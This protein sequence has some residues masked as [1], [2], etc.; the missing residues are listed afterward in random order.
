MTCPNS[1]IRLFLRLEPDIPKLT[2]QNGIKTRVVNGHAQVYKS[3]E[4]L[5]LE[6]KYLSLLSP[7][8]P[9]KPWNCPIHLATVWYFRMPQK[10]GFVDAVA[11]KTTK[12]DTDNLVKTLKDCL[13][14]AGFFK[15]DAL[16]CLESI[17]KMWAT[18]LQPHGV[19]ICMRKLS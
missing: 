12:P 19:E 18:P 15:D 9:Q 7:H 14:R 6:A 13:A 5:D 11:W 2:H 10:C 16:V 17:A 3:P 8:A 4:L 1:E